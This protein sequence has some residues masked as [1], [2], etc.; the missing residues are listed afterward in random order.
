MA[1][2]IEPPPRGI[3]LATIASVPI[4]L[5]WS[6][7]L[8]G[9][10]IIVLIGP[11]TAA[12]FG[13]VTGYSIAAVYALALLLS[14]LA[15]EAAHA[16][17]AR[18]FGHKVHRV[19]ADLWGGH[20][21]FDASHGTAWSAATIAIVGPLT[22]GV[23]AALA[24]GGVVVSGSE[25]T[26]SLLSGVAFVNGALALFNL[27]PGLPLDGGQVVESL[28]W[29][30][31]GDQSRARVI[32]GWA[33]RVLVVLIVV[34]IIGVPLARGA[35]P[36][37]SI[38]LW[39][40]LIGAFLWSGAT[41]AIAQGQALGTLRGL[42]VAAV[43]E[44]AA[45]IGGDRPLT[46]LTSL[47]ALPVV[48]DDAGR[49][50]GLIDHDALRSVPPDAVASTPVSA[51]TTPAPA[52]WTT[53]LRVGSEALDLVRAFQSSGSSIVAVTSGGRLHAVA[54]AARVNAALSRN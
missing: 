29:A 31:T 3:R 15:H 14:V 42:D 11:G 13:S 19:V 26:V 12:R 33:G 2:P 54:R 8:L 53:E 5:G 50:I 41:S 30:A 10:I 27:L 48:V 51:V 22:N 7:L 44:P 40:A 4:Y 28:I 36:D 1:E 20:T 43:L 21:A 9:V 52:A 34:A 39:T 45:A 37:L 32:A 49:P 6:W 47:R 17:A 16:V 46:E 23:I 24:F 18:A 35:T 38:T 25:V